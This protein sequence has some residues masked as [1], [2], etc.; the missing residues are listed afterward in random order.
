MG[1]NFRLA[2]VKQRPFLLRE[3]EL[4]LDLKSELKEKDSTFSTNLSLA[5]SVLFRYFI[6][7]DPSQKPCIDRGQKPVGAG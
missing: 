2:M 7:P 1:S 3:A 4:T 6:L 5:R